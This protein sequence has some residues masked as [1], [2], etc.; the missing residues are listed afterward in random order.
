MSSNSDKYVIFD[1]ETTGFNPQHGARI[2][3]IG[4]V[5]IEN[6]KIGDLKHARKLY[7]RESGCPLAGLNMIAIRGTH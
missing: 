4:A 7:A 6:G 2:I 1:V 3:E 5:H